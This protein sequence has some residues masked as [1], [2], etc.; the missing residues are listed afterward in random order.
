MVQF[1]RF[2][3]RQSMRTLGPLDVIFCRNVLICFDFETKKQIL[4][5]LRGCLYSGGYLLLGG[6]ENTL[7]LSDQFEREAFGKAVVYRAA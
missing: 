2:D 7:G 5:E 1:V 6:T 3:L 4:S